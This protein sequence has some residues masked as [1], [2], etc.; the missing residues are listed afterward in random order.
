[1]SNEQ[2]LDSMTA[3]E[4][5]RARKQMS[6]QAVKLAISSRWDEAAH[7]NRE[8]IRV[9][10]DE[11]E[12]LNRL[13]KSLTELGQV[14]E[15]RH[16]YGRSLAME[17]TNTIARKNLDKLATMTDAVTSAQAQSQLDTRLFIEETGKATVATL[18][19]VDADNSA[20][21]DAGD[22]V[23]LEV[24]GNAVNVKT[25]AGDYIGMVEPRIGLRLSKMMAEGNQYSAAMVS[26]TAGFKVMISETFQAPSMIGRVS[27]PTAKA[28]ASG[29]E[30]R[31]YTRRGLLRNQ[32]GDDIE[33]GDDEPE[34]TNDD[35]DGWTETSEDDLGGGTVDVNVDTDDDE[36]FD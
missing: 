29:T 19:A 34:D 14:T 31:A 10:G 6:D 11:P 3:E 2:S 8:Y 25:Q 4:R 23:E 24:Q 13:G 7:V 16:I 1:M 27:F 9:F 35:D 22:L 30:V 15:A 26:V 33:Y 18:Q 5:A 36:G 28:T 21:V 20:A 17:P 32:G 12:A